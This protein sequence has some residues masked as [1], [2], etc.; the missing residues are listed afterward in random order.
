MPN[1]ALHPV[2][3]HKG[4]LTWDTPPVL[5]P[6][7]SRREYA[8]PPGTHSPHITLCFARNPARNVPARGLCLIWKCPETL[9]TGGRSKR[10]GSVWLVTPTSIYGREAHRVVPLAIPLSLE[11]K[12]DGLG[13]PL[14]TPASALH[15]KRTALCDSSQLKTS[16]GSSTATPSCVSHKT[17]FQLEPAR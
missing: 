11:C 1:P 3:I 13:A 14:T 2:A 15:V 12:R 4:A 6:R 9:R 16:G 17:C 8:L 7:A 5:H 10:D